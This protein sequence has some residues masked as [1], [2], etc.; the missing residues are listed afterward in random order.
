MCPI[1]FENA[2]KEL[3][4]IS[5]KQL[6][7]LFN[8][9]Y[10]NEVDSYDITEDLFLVRNARVEILTGLFGNEALLLSEMRILIIRKGWTKPIV[11]LQPQCFE[12]GDLVFLGRNG[13]LQMES[14]SDDVDGFGISMSDN[15]FHLVTGGHIPKAFDGRLRNFHFRLLPTE[16]DFLDRLHQLIFENNPQKGCSTQVTLHLINS[17]LWY[18][19]QLWGRHEATERLSF[20]REQRLFHDFIQLV[21]QHAPQQHNIDFYA[22][23][24]FLSPRYMSTIVKKVSGR[25]AKEWID[26]AI[27]ARIKVE[28]RHTDKQ[29]ALI[30]DEMNFPNASFFCKYFKR[31]T[32][33]TPMEYKMS[34][35][36]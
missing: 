15:L 17:F 34:K 12:A 16:M 20:S 22:N 7:H 2:M 27:I 13:I 24:L 4:Q 14:F 36:T 26:E 19:D 6:K 1:S 31:M 11:N 32:G 5:F 21:N 25:A 29:V 23:H 10:D 18:I 8:Y 28:L 9:D 30:S 35:T 3:H 33:M